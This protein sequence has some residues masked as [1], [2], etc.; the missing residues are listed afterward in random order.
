MDG[1]KNVNGK[2]IVDINYVKY[3][4]NELDRLNNFDLSKID[5]YDGSKKLTIND[6]LIND[7]KFIGLLNEDFISMD[8]I[9]KEIIQEEIE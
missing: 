6:S 8:F 1:I 9:N 5:F 3:L 7:F 2:L 4:I